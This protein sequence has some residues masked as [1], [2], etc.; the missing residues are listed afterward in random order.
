MALPA[1][2]GAEHFIAKLRQLIGGSSSISTTASSVNT[3]IRARVG[4]PIVLQVQQGQQVCEVKLGPV[5]ALEPND[6]SL[7][8]L[9]SVLGD[10]SVSVVYE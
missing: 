7:A 4:C 2:Q 5:Y 8:Q 10:G 3:P 9:Q 6:R 1:D